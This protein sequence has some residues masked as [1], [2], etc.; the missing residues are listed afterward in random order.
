[1]TEKQSQPIQPSIK[2]PERQSNIELL[3]IFSIIGVIVLH[4]NNPIMGGGMNYVNADSINFYIM[5]YLQAIFVCAVDTFVLISG[6][7]LCQSTR[8]NLWRPIELIL[9]LVLLNLGIYLASVV[10][11]GKVLSI[12]TVIGCFV[13][14]NYFVILYSTL[15]IISPFLNIIVEQKSFNKFMIVL[16]LLFS[17]WPTVV[18]ILSEI[19]GKEIFGLST[20]GNWGSQS[21][22]T[23]VNFIVIY[24]VGAWVRKN[25]ASEY[26]QAYHMNHAALTYDAD[27]STNQSQDRIGTNRTNRT[28][29]LNILTFLV[30]ALFITFFIIV[31]ERAGIIL[32]RSSTAYFNPLVICEAVL[33]FKVFQDIKIGTVKW[34]NRIAGST[35]TVFL[36]HAYLL[37]Y[38]NIQNYVNSAAYIPHLLVSVVVLFGSSYI[39]YIVYNIVTESVLKNVKKCIRLPVIDAEK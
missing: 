1:M 21:G 5:H 39:V 20:I 7:F 4:Y 6:Y 24:F 28:M 11:K 19:R 23:I 3:R 22:Y 37:K 34:I 12:K 14:A 32:R 36:F 17:I 10:I 38:L 25:E 33:L 9:Q 13:P 2:P 16:L 35:F 8:R 30:I 18:D 31:E 27:D 26:N 29:L 15:F